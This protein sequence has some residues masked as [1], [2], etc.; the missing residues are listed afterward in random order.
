MSNLT[1]PTLTVAFKQRASTAVAR[2]QKGTVALIIR[3]AVAAAKDLQYTLTS[4][5]QIPATLGVA[6]QAS[7]RRVFSGNTNPPA[8]YAGRIS[9]CRPGRGTDRM[10]LVY[11]SGDVPC[12]GFS[13][14]DNCHI[15]AHW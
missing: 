11:I 5:A 8:L 4:T 9:R 1:M 14:F 7:I 12:G 13:V 3:D 15:F 10:A 2:S 6:N